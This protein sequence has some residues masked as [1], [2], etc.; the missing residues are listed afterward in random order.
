MKGLMENDKEKEKLS[1]R[2]VAWTTVRVE[3][4]VK[5]EKREVF[6]G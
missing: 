2:L 5:N 3:K 4:E 6:C 1:K